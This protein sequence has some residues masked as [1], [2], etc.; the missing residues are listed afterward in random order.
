[1]LAL[2]FPDL[3]T[4]VFVAYRTDNSP[5]LPVTDVQTVREKKAT[6]DGT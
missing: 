3:K 4:L 6:M 5:A 2:L 1:M